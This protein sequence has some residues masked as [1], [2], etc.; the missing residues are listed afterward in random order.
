MDSAS[1]FVKK[2]S[3]ERPQYLTSLRQ[4]MESL[5]GESE[6]IRCWPSGQEDLSALQR[7]LCHV[8]QVDRLVPELEGPDVKR[9]KELE[10][11]NSP[12]K[13]TRIQG[14]RIL[15]QLLSSHS[16]STCPLLVS[17]VEHAR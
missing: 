14:L 12:L 4:S 17:F 15:S 1:S 7:Q 9:L 8:L 5:S 3:P 10:H 6:K 13:R 11:D 2:F 16:V